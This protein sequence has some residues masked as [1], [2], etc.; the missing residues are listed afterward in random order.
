M[1]HRK[2]NG[3]AAE[4]RIQDVEEMKLRKCRAFRQFNFWDFKDE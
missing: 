2:K 4:D 1:F 3:T